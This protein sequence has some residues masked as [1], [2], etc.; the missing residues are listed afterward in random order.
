MVQDVRQITAAHWQPRLGSHGE[1]VE[2]LDDIH[3]CIRIILLT[4]K[5][6]DPHRPEFG[7]DLWHYLDHPMEEAV[8]H[9]V[10]EGVDALRRWEQRIEVVRLVPV[11]LG[12]AHMHITVEWRLDGQGELIATEVR[13]AVA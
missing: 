12:R 4:P 8:P 9:V 5:G 3:Q 13:D 10:R 1:I 2:G 11:Q 6:S 7:S